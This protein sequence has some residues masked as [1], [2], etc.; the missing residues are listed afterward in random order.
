MLPWRCK[1]LGGRTPGVAPAPKTAEWVSKFCAKK[2][3]SCLLQKCCRDPGHTCFQKDGNF[4]RCGHTCAKGMHLDDQDN[5]KNWTCKQL[6]GRTPG[7]VLVP[8][9]QKLAPWVKDHCAD[10]H[11]NCAVSK[12]CKDKN[13][14]CFEQQPGHAQCLY[15]CLAKNT[16]F[17]HHHQCAMEAKGNTSKKCKHNGKTWTCRELGPRTLPTTWGSPSLFCTHVMRLH[18]YEVNIVKLQLQQDETFRGGIFACDQY[19]IYASDTPRGSFL[20]MGPYGPV[21]TR[22]FRSAPVWIS[23][24]NTAAN[25][26]LFMNFWEAVRWDLQYKCCDWTIKAD[27]DA[28]L[29]PDRMRGALSHRMGGAS[30]ITT[31]DK[32][33]SVGPMMFGATEAISTQGLERYFSNENACR[34]MPWQP[35]GEDKWMGICLKA[36]GVSPVFDGGFVGDNLCYGANCQNG[37]S[38][39]YHPFKDPNDGCGVIDRLRVDVRFSATVHVFFRHPSRLDVG[40]IAGVEGHRHHCGGPPA[41]VGGLGMS[42]PQ[43]GQN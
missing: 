33:F 4:A 39:S 37:H 42:H 21:R 20:G 36:L 9:P 1:Q 12:C 17:A 14:Q 13:M 35:W 15:T 40:G 24:D 18:S 32:G 5:W 25:T 11:E 3:E 30:F 29:L 43:K 6:G 41:V 19:A 10:M 23:Q 31:C 16:K 26:L 7:P 8:R 2:N 22:W 34:S 27:P 28:V 38:S